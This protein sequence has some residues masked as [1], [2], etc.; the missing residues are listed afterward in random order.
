M[1]KTVVLSD[2]HLGYEGF[3]EVEFKGFLDFLETEG[4]VSRLVL[5][6]DM[7]ELWRTDP[8]KSFSIAHGYLERL[9][10][11]AKET[12]YVVG[13]HDYH[14]RPSCLIS[15]AGDEFAGTIAY[16][17]YLV[18]GDLFLIHG[19]YFDIHGLPIWENTI[20]AVYE[21]IYHMDKPMVASLE[22]CFWDPIQLLRK[23]IQLYQKSPAKAKLQSPAEY[24]STIVNLKKR[25][26]V[27][28]LDRGIKYLTD[29]PDVAVQM[30]VPTYLR[31]HLPDQL[32][33][34]VDPTA[35]K[36]IDTAPRR[37]LLSKRNPVELAREISGNAGI[38]KVIYGHTH[39]AENSPSKGYWNTGSWVDGEST[40][41]EIQDGQVQ[42]Y[43]FKQ[44]KKT[45]IAEEDHAS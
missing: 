41:A 45:A 25:S 36:K 39:K 9:H 3:N 32:P 8:V 2:C 13:N 20:Y 21:A 35:M 17:P 6:G 42:V 14:I 4:G 12:Y 10:Q 43:R 23:W 5:L 44:G 22:G 1:R 34:L 28:R 18:D 29:K 11:L 40:F 24:L 37:S 7:L 38:G 27:K 19:D 31:H 26:E 15:G 33:L 30:F 16:H